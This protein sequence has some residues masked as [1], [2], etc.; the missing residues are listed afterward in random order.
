MQRVRHTCCNLHICIK[1]RTFR[2]QNGTILI[3]YKYKDCNSY[4]HE[5]QTSRIQSLNKE[6]LWKSKDKG[7]HWNYDAGSPSHML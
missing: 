7:S 4:L 6:G 1:K 2:S 3:K 5:K